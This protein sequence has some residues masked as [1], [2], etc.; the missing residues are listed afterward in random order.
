M[1]N[2]YVRRGKRE[3]RMNKDGRIERNRREGRQFFMLKK[4]ER[5]EERSGERREDREAT[6]GMDEIQEESPHADVKS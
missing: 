4:K 1:G 5:K 6:A 2:M 3:S